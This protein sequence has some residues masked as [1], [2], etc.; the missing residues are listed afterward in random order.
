MKTPVYLDHHAT[1]PLDPRVLDVVT[2]VTRDHFGN[3]ASAGH[4]FGWAAARLVETA[5]EQVAGLIGA[6]PREIVFTSGATEA[7]N[8]ALLG[9]ARAA[10]GGGRR[11]LVRTNLEHPAVSAPLDHLAA[12]EGWRVRVVTSGP[13]GLV[14][15]EAVAA[16][17]DA[18]TLLVAVIGAQN[19]V[20]TVQP[21]AEIAA[22]C[23]RVGALL[24]VDAAQAAG[25][26]DL[27]VARDGLD[28]VALSAHKLYGPKGVGA[29]YV[30]RRD[31]RVTL[32]PLVFGG[33]QE[34]GLRAGTLNVPAI[35]GFGEA[36]RLAAA[37][38]EEENRRVRSLRDRLWEGLRSALPDV[39]LN[40]DPERRLPGNLNVSF[41]GVPRGRLVGALTTLAL[42]TGAACSS[43]DGEPSPVL[44]ALGVPDDLAAASLRIGLG[45]F[46]TEA[47]VDF[48][49][50]TII[51]AVRRLRG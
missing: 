5:R 43:A 6:A 18:D 24:H 4:A 49:A 39:H 13:D 36:C 44:A 10:A 33:G 48:A 2:R 3:P 46:T 37:E 14:A 22:V 9:A 21:L 50:E 45:R 41:G 23:R 7:D 47:E 27:D 25:R 51:A 28:L 26:V 30:R 1:T 31:P 42:S 35:V 17:V 8:L 32:A 40:G 20:G 19:E 15:P 11:T 16:V 38:R 12:H 34:R 29:L